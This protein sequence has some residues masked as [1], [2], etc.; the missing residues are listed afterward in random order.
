MQVAAGYV[1]HVGSMSRGTLKRG[2]LISAEVDHVRRGR[3]VPNHTF[4]H[5]LNFALREVL[6]PYDLSHETMGGTLRPLRIQLGMLSELDSLARLH[7]VSCESCRSLGITWTK[8][9]L[10]YSQTGSAS[11]F[12][13][14]GQLMVPPLGGLKASAMSSLRRK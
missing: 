4:T 6:T 12:R 8:R 2:A 10:L 1:L 11:T 14:V 7:T 5:V 9:G 13:I 3:I